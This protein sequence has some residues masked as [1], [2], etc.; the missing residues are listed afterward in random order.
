MKIVYDREA[1][2]IVSMDNTVI[3]ASTALPTPPGGF[4]YRDVQDPDVLELL[5]PAI[6]EAA[7]LGAVELGSVDADFN[8]A[9]QPNVDSNGD[10]APPGTSENRG[11]ESVLGNFV[12]D[13]QY[14]SAN[15]DTAIDIAFMNPGGLRKDIA[16][17]PDGGVVTFKEAADVQPFANSLFTQT[18]TGAQVKQV[19]EEQWQPAGR[20]G[21]S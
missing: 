17:A 7:V 3:D 2:Q 19:L 13:V 12:A 4:S 10:P 8:R 1:D 5:Q 6:D 16:F 9:V 18:L 20:V 15:Q 21:R 11:A 14:W